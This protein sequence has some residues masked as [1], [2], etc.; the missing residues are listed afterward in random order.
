[1]S[2]ERILAGYSL[3]KKWNLETRPFFFLP[4]PT[5][6]TN[7]LTLT[8]NT[9]G[10]GQPYS[11]D[12]LVADPLYEYNS[13]FSGERTAAQQAAEHIAAGGFTNAREKNRGLRK[14]GVCP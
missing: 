11:M 5:D 3:E 10:T 13:T 9:T 8:T 14:T 2:N 4:P 12:S 6:V 7:T 1:V